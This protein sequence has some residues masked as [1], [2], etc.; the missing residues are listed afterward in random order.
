[1][2]NDPKL[3][4]IGEFSQIS[5]L[6]V[7]ALRFYDDKGLLK[8]ARADAVTDYRYYDAA[9]AERARVIARLRELQFSLDDIARILA[10]CGDESDLLEAL[11]RQQRAIAERMRADRKVVGM[12]EKMI[13][14]ETRAAELVKGSSFQVEEKQLEPMVIAGMRMKGRY[15]E[16]G[17]GFATV[18]RAMG[19]HL[20]GKIGRAH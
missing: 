17:R 4:S 2:Q 1:M 9:C 5:G 15:E 11:R 10:E 14:E 12:L 18:A 19:R 7:K 16:C 13:G 6:S 20:G 8:P 3:F